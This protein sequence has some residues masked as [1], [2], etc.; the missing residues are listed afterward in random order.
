MGLFAW[1]LHR[2]PEGAPP[3]LRG[4]FSLR[5]VSRNI[6]FCF[7]PLGV[8]LSHL[9]LALDLLSLFI[10][11]P[12]SSPLY[13][14]ECI[15]YGNYIHRVG[16]LPTAEAREVVLAGGL[17]Y[18]A[19]GYSGLKVIDVSIPSNP[20]LV[21]STDTPDF[22]FSIAVSGALACIADGIGGLQVIDISDPSVP[23]IVGHVINTVCTRGRA[24]RLARLRCGWILWTPSRRSFQSRF[25][26]DR[27]R[28]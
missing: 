26:D 10:A 4:H 2:R 1:A 17:A 28:R 14:E 7:R 9:L 11:S 23:S 13:A 8:K 27:R 16:S 25:A 21:G 20:R 6:R 24:P 3:R 5:M 15:D 22:A 19:D 12:L 18:V